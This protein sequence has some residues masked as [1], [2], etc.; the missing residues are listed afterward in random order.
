MA[1]A[2]I[3]IHEEGRLQICDFGVAGIL[4]SKVDK[5]STWIG[6]PHWMPP[7]MF[8]TRGGEAHQ[9]GS[10]LDVWAYGC[11]LFEFATGN[12]PNAG[13]RERM[14]IGRSLGRLTPKLEG[15]E[16]S[17]QLKDLV[18]FSLNSDPATRPTMGTILGHPYL[19]DSSGTYPTS[20]LSELVRVFYQWAQRGG[21]R[22]SLFHPGGAVAA[23]FPDTSSLEEDWNF[24]TTDGF[25]RRFSILDLDQLSASLAELEGEQTPATAMPDPSTSSDDASAEMTPTDKANF[26]ERVKRGAAAMEGLFDEDKP[27]YKYET[28][29][30]FVPVE[31]E[32]RYSD[33]PLRTV[34]DRSSVTSTFI[35]INLGAFDS[36]HYAAGSASNHPFQLADADTIRA[37]RSSLRSSRNSNEDHSRSRAGS[38]SDQEPSYQG[39]RP[40]TMDWKF[41]SVAMPTTT[42]QAESVES[43]ETSAQAERRATR[44]WKFPVMTTEEEDL[45]VNMPVTWV[46]SAAVRRPPVTS[47]LDFT[48]ANNPS[49]DSM[50]ESRPSTAV[51]TVSTASDYD[52]FRFDRLT[53]PGLPN[54]TETPEYADYRKSVLDGPGPDEE[55]DT[56]EEEPTTTEGQSAPFTATRV[57]RDAPTSPST[58]APLTAQMTALNSTRNIQRPIPFPLIQ[59]PSVHSLMTGADDATVTAELD[60]LL[61]D[62]QFA[63]NSTIEAVQSRD[64][65]RS[66]Q[67]SDD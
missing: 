20:S 15:G 39:P 25:E 40:P 59:P 3:L 45:D 48:H 23:E 63:L 22:I 60:R 17:D 31:Q 44:D 58:I 34:T 19:A 50:A 18:S 66:R 47:Q 5:R 29:N 33:L 57:G 14:Q 30:D 12:P 16:F 64:A 8:S 11:T 61:D 4:Q 46:P 35:D 37:N 28:K 9:Y 10:E 6:T 36:A 1:A 56:E 38:E 26:D 55:E 21:Q 41:P 51:S 67:P 52:P 32:Q 24:S 54:L 62:F 65:S 43:P 27:T 13:L 7:E 53:S 2:N 42:D 49:I